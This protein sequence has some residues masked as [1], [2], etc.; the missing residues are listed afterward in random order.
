VCP[1]CDD[2]PGREIP[3]HARWR[4]LTFHIATRHAGR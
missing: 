4:W 2:K 3:P 1:H